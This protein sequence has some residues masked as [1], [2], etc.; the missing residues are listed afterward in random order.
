MVF[1]DHLSDRR[2]LIFFPKNVDCHNLISEN[3]IDQGI[4]YAQIKNI[5]QLHFLKF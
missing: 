5:F 3:N 4:I 1:N 2:I